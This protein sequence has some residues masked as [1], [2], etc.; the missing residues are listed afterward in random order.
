MRGP[1]PAGIPVYMWTGAPVPPDAFALPP[2][3]PLADAARNIVILLVDQPLFDYRSHWQIYFEQL[4]KGLDRERNLLL[5]V[6]IGA[7]AHRVSSALSA[8]NCVPVEDPQAVADD[9]R[10][11]Q[12]VLTAILR[13]DLAAAQ[14]EA[15]DALCFSLTRQM[16]GDGKARIILGGKLKG[17]RGR[18][19]GIVEEAL[20]TISLG[21]P[22]Y[23]VG[24][25]GGAARAVFD[26]ITGM[27][28]EPS[29]RAAWDEHCSDQKV[30]ETNAAYDQ[31]AQDLQLDLRVDHEAMLQSF[32]NLGPDELAKRNKLSWTENERLASSRDIHEIMALLV[33]GLTQVALPI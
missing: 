33:R 12:A 2:Q 19:P 16:A 22:L 17:Y 29:L 25:F 1:R 21:L 26:A 32:K 7:E 20:E 5:P 28:C 31:L 4:A 13:L 18:Y 3:P 24:G 6:S 10:I 15:L 9:E 8:L 11:F 23:I 27:D 14:P 30:R